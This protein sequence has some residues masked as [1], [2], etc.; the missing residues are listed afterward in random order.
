MIE[1]NNF[2]NFAVDKRFF[3]GVAKMILKGENREMENLSIAFV[4][5]KEI[6][7][8]NKKYRK[9]DRPTDILSFERMPNFENDFSEVIIC[10]E[11]AKGK[12]DYKT[13]LKREIIKV[14]IHGILHVLGYNHETSKSEEEKMFKKQEYYFSKII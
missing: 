12:K 3:L 10:P 11:F 7:K 5:T 1:I 9:K 4:S 8:I 2:T 6:Q 13:T 14:L